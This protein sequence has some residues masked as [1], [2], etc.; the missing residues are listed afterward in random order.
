M[1]EIDDLKTD[2][3]SPIKVIISL[4]SIAIIV[5][6]LAL[7]VVSSF[8][9][10]QLQLNTLIAIVLIEFSFNIASF[11]F[12]R[13]KAVVSDIHVMVQ[14]LFDVICLGALLYF[15]GGA[16]NAFVS[17][18]L[19]PIAIASI[20][21]PLISAA[22]ITLAAVLTYSF[23]LLFVPMHHHGSMEG[24][25]TAMWVNFIF[26]AIV[27]VFIINQLLKSI[28]VKDAELARYREEQL[29]QE[30]I[31]ALGIASAQVS[32]DIATPVGSLK[33]LVEELKEL[34][35]DDTDLIDQIEQLVD[36]CS[37]K[38]ASFRERADEISSH[39]LIEQNGSEI[40][41]M[42]R[43]Q[44]LLYYPNINFSF[45]QS[46]L[47]T[48]SLV[49]V[50]N[51][52]FPAVLNIINNSVNASLKSGNNA[53]CVSIKTQTNK[54]LLSIIDEGSGFNKQLITKLGKQVIKSQ[55]GM[56]MALLLSNRSI[57]NLGG[58][59]EIMNNVNQGATVKIVLPLVAK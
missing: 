58:S 15:S 32:H 43:K 45:E 7:I 35:I 2:K 8:F 36:R 34:P 37:D 33:F 29:S 47:D 4:R 39:Q 55:T 59:I 6:I 54:L 10:Y 16:T 24:H 48:A 3:L 28:R 51:S 21:L 19:I 11:Y 44:C 20:S 52:F 5:Q 53:V 40:I 27:V 12:Y 23:L 26:S 18:L 17:L 38:L 57:E 25:Y 1:F 49:F 9:D 30:N 13:L 14:L 42:I 41:E 56:G 31:I 46:E 50:D 22:L